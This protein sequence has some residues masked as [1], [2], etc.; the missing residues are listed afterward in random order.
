MNVLAGTRRILIAGIA[1]A[2]L[3][4]TAAAQEQGW[5]QIP[6]D[7]QRIEHFEIGSEETRFGRLEFVGGLE[8]VSSSGELGGMSGIRF[9]PGGTGFIGVMDTGKFFAGRI[10]RDDAGHL[11]GIET[12][13][14]SPMYGP[15]GAVIDEKWLVD[16]EGIALQDDAILVSF[17]REHRVGVFDRAGWPTGPEAD[18]LDILIP[19]AELRH[20]QGL[21]TVAIS[22]GD[23]PLE[24]S[25][26][27]VAEGSV[28]A[29]GDLFAAVLSGPEAGVFFVRQHEPYNV[30]DGTFLADGDLLLL[31]RRFSITGGVGMQIRRIEADDI[32]PGATVDGPV[33]LEADFGYQIDN[34]E[35][36]D[37]VA[38]DDGSISIF[39]ASD[40]N[41]SF[42]Q[43]NLLLE[44]RLTE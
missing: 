33:L 44:F 24:G 16:A 41:H 10:E 19:E 5:T 30:T 2:V 18:T 21:E 7:V 23:G 6:I 42:L 11:A 40:D 3:A 1:L 28:N 38:M 25:V 36:I 15:E 12:F 32:R 9:E 20:N 34:M 29:E 4:P 26:V 39:L 37:A 17:E 14:V 35:G 43:R 8:M 22:P 27:V 31:E 13:A